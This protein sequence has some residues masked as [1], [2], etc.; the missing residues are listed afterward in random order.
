MQIELAWPRL[1]DRPALAEA[2][3]IAAGAAIGAVF[4][5]TTLYPAVWLAIG[6]GVG[7]LANRLVAARR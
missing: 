1:S 7:L 6:V 2:A 4:G 3:R 5:A